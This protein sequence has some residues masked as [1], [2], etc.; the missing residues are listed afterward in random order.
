MIIN[1]REKKQVAYTVTDTHTVT[2]TDAYR[3]RHRQTHTNIQTH[4]DTQWHTHTH[5]R[6]H[7]RTHT[8][9]HTHNVSRQIGTIRAAR[10]ESQKMEIILPHAG[11]NMICTK[12]AIINDTDVLF[13][14]KG[15]IRPICCNISWLHYA[16]W[17]KRGTLQRQFL[18]VLITE[19]V[20]NPA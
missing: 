17:L 2:D 18:M 4:T 10:Y 12:C 1:W 8:H 14:H 7:T 3:H 11:G 20:S 9:T 13:L 15:R 19:H 5:A 6:T 16:L